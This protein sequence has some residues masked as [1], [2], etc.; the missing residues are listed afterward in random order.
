[1]AGSKEDVETVRA[2]FQAYSQA[3]MRNLAAKIPADPRPE[4]EAQ[5]AGCYQAP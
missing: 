3:W 5:V 2:F 1:M 4:F